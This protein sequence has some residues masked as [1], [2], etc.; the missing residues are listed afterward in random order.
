MKDSKSSLEY[1]GFKPKEAQIYLALLELGEASVVQIAKKTGIKRT[2]VYNILPDFINR[3][4]ITSAVRKKRKVYFIED[5]R[6][7]KNDLKE[8]ESVIDKL[9]PELLAIQNIL[10]SKPRITFYEGVGGMKDLYQDTFDSCKEGDV[11]L[12]FTGLAD[13]LKLMPQEYN[14]YYI[15]ERVRRKIRIR[16]IASNSPTARAWKNSA[17]QELREIKIIDNPEFNFDGDM[18]IYANKVALISYRENFMGVIIE[19]KEINQMQIAAFELMWNS[20]K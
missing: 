5:P 20:V 12:S 9:M 10:P 3:G 16:I 11:I 4:I 14:D 18:E 1:L 19:S 8:K 13:F 17:V 6:S 15:K 2:T 7:L